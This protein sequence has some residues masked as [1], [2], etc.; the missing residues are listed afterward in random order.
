MIGYKIYYVS[1]LCL[2][3]RSIAHNNCDWRNI[4]A[5]QPEGFKGQTA[6]EKE[7]IKDLSK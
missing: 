3:V 6:N 1:R 7:I 2:S 4:E 5:L